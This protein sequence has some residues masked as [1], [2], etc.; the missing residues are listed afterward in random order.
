MKPPKFLWSILAI[1]LVALLAAPAAAQAPV[2]NAVFFY[3]PTCNHC[4]EVME[5]DLPPLVQKYPGQLDIVGVDVNHE[6]GSNLYQAMLARYNVPDDRI[7]V[8]TLVVGDTVLV[9][10]DEI[11]EQL[12]GIVEKALAAGGLDWPDIPGLGEVLAAQ[13]EG[14]VAFQA[15]AP[16]AQEPSNG[17]IAKFMLEPVEN[18]LAVLVLLLM[19]AS[20]VL[21]AYSYLQ[22][23]DHRLFNWPRLAIP[24]LSFVG[25]GVAGYLAY[26]YLTD[27]A[28]ICGPSG[29]CGNVQNSEYSYLFGIIPV[30][31][32]G[33]VGYLSIAAAWLLYEFGPK[34]ARKLAALAM[35]GFAWFGILFTIY[36]TFLEPFVIG[37]SCL[38]C[39]GSAIIMTLVFLATTG[40][41][42]SAMQ[43]DS[44]R[45]EDDFDEEFEDQP[46]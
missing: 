37:A 27:T 20:V 21:V 26:S 28:V 17:P 45:Y 38:W 23:N 13:P 41:A 40:P 36:L 34:S 16:P 43:L 25:I 6:V 11:P 14:T 9:G 24:A 39:L 22:G 5:N 42:L 29:G 19:V 44:D 8:P 18:S 46:A 3:S 2:V 4:H 33:V 12:P 30:A 7:G 1:A 15:P 35:W 31:L 32:L 10:A